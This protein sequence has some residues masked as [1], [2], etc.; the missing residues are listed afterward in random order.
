MDIIFVPILKV[1]LVVLNI[2]EVFLLG[3]VVF[4]WL[5]YFGVINRYNPL[6]YVVH[7]FLFAITE[8]LLRPIRQFLPS[9]GDFDL[10]PV[11]LVV[12]IYFI[13]QV[14]Y[15]ALAHFPL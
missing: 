15:R 3:Y 1:L 4:G 7:N 8:P 6:V 11:I 9:V 2:Y 12:L 10:S 5:E 14:I 13:E